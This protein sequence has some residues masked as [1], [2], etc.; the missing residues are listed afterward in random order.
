M[1][2]TGT[3]RIAQTGKDTPRLNLGLFLRV[4]KETDANYLID[5]NGARLIRKPSG[6]QVNVLLI[7]NYHGGVPDS[8]YAG[9][10]EITRQVWGE[11]LPQTIETVGDTRGLD[12]VPYGYAINSGIRRAA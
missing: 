6:D 8:V 12:E 5:E 10:E 9:L 11:G 3:L 2:K 1:E 7:G 4:A